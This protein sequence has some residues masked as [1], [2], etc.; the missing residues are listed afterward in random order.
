MAGRQ[1]GKTLVGIAEICMAAMENRRMC[2]WISPNYKVK[3]RAWR[4]LLEFLPPEV[5][6]K[7]NET[8]SYVR[9]IN[10]SE[11]WVKSADAPDSLV[12]ES[13]DFAV[14]DE[15]GQWKPTAWYQGILPMFA[16]RPEARAIL[17]GT[18]RGKNWFHRV[19]LQGLGA[20]KDADYD[21]FHWKSEDSPYVSKSFLDEQRRNVPQDT[22]L[23]EYEANPL[24]NAKSVF[25]HFRQCIRLYPML[26]DQFMCLGVDVARKVDFSAVIAMNGK[27]QVTEIER[28]QDDW[29]EQERKVVTASFRNSFA[30]GIVDATGE[31]DV[32]IA[33]LREKGMQVEEFIFSNASKARLIQNLVVD[34]EQSQI[35][36]PNHEQLIAELDAYE[37]EYDEDTRKLT[38]GAPDGQHDDLVIALALAAWGQRG[39]PAYLTLDR[40]ASYM[41]GGPRSSAPVRGSYM[42]RR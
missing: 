7:K 31:G 28:F 22:Y 20:N 33:H 39:V 17:I 8:E 38:Y 5:V 1:S 27:K 21:S 10:G 4:G 3:P 34:F 23:Q 25:R 9:L 19:W 37:Y 26:P 13:L 30:R 41:G 29:P 32:F 14:A 15:A 36:I 12:S 11:I 18:P 24:D 42:G 35:S 16:A 2:W 6:D 40:S